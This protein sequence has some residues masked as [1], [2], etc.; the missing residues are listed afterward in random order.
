MTRPLRVASFHCQGIQD[1]CHC[2]MS[3]VIVRPTPAS[4]IG[5]NQFSAI[6]LHRIWKKA[7][8]TLNAI[9]G[10]KLFWLLQFNFVPDNC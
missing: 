5:A 4:L 8:F 7:F 2:H 9:I 1:R 6:S 3:R 10:E